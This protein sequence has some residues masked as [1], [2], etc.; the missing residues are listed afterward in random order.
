MNLN[1][2]G[3]LIMKRILNL[4]LSFVYIICI[5]FFF[6]TCAGQFVC[7][8]TRKHNSDYWFVIVGLVLLALYCFVLYQVCQHSILKKWVMVLHTILTYLEISVVIGPIMLAH[9][10]GARICWEWEWEIFV[11]QIML[12]S[13]RI[14][15]NRYLRSGQ[16]S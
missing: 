2:R 15:I 3:A 1:H 10:D 6:I 8:E 11:L 9:L 14:G 7:P 5:G 12:L 16:L 4:S 13:V